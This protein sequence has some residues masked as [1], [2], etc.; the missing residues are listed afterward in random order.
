MIKYF[1]FLLSIVHTTIYYLQG[2]DPLD[3]H[4]VVTTDE[5]TQIRELV[6]I[7]Q[8]DGEQLQRL[9]KGPSNLLHHV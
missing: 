4:G 9:V 3:E 2:L 5:I 7:I 6:V 1:I 8:R